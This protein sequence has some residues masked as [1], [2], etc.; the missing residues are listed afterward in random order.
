MTNP[1][2]RPRDAP[3]RFYT[4]HHDYTTAKARTIVAQIYESFPNLVR[5]DPQRIQERFGVP[6]RTTSNWYKTWTR[7]P[8]WRPWD[9]S[10]RSLSHRMFDDGEERQISDRIR[11]E[12]ILPGMLF[13][14]D[15]FRVLIMQEHL[16]RYGSEDE[17]GEEGGEN[18][19]WTRIPDFHVS[20]GFI[21]DFKRRNGFS[22]RRAHFKRRSRVNPER[23]AAWM[24]EIEHLLSTVPPDTIYNADETSWRL[25]PNGVT[26]WAE[27]GSENISITTRGDEKECLTVMATIRADGKRVPLYILARGKTARVE[28]SQI[29]PVAPHARDHSESGWMTKETYERYLRFLSEQ[30]NG[31]PIH[32][33][34]DIYPVHVQATARALAESLNITLHFIPSGMTDQYQPLDRRVFGCL[35]SSAR[36]CFMRRAFQERTRRVE[37][38]DAVRILIQCWKGILEETI[39]SS[40][41]IYSGGVPQWGLED[42]DENERTQ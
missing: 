6:A 15:D 29:G 26:T 42:E 28:E 4:A 27:R 25:Y 10:R 33:L 19:A 38:K 9:T 17:E 41:S 21:H 1:G 3:L 30:A 11:S 34:L 36:K 12:L 13:T 8:S 37:K 16:S 31:A 40:W 5:G 7:D 35:K 18:D 2:R 32:L 24:Q 39:R 23:A 22:S 14:D 20:D